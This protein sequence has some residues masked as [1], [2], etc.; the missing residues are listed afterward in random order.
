[1]IIRPKRK[2]KKK[3]KQHSN[4]YRNIQ[5]D[6]IEDFLQPSPLPKVK[7]KGTPDIIRDSFGESLVSDWLRKHGIKFI[8]EKTFK[9]L[10]NPATNAHLRFDFYL[11]EKNMC[12]EFDGKQHFETCKKFDGLDKNEVIK[13]QFRDS[14]KD[15][16][17]EYRGMKMLRISYKQI[18][19][20]EHILCIN[21]L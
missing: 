11:P 9:D 3:R 19:K 5:V 6:N 13:R 16:F 15:R 7:F 4:T 17:C 14:I 20:I 10:K 21:C 18:A 12:I 2:G 8:R 1:M